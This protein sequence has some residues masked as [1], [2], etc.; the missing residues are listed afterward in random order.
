M[1]F[2]KNNLKGSVCIVLT[3]L[4]L[5]LYSFA[6]ACTD[7]VKISSAE[8]M[9]SKAGELGLAAG[10]SDYNTELKNVYGLYAVSDTNAASED[11]TECFEKSL[12]LKSQTENY[13]NM[14]LFEKEKIS[15]EYPQYAVLA[16]PDILK[17]Q[18]LEYH[19]YEEIS[20]ALRQFISKFDDNKTLNDISS[21]DDVPDD[22]GDSGISGEDALDF[23]QKFTDREGSVSAKNNHSES[24]KSSV[25][26]EQTGLI[27]EMFGKTEKYDLSEVFNND[28]E[29]EYDRKNLY[30]K[31]FYDSF[32]TVKELFS[33]GDIENISDAFITSEYILDYFS[34][35]TDENKKRD[36]E[37][38]N[39]SENNNYLYGRE[40]EYILCGKDDPDRNAESVKTA[41]FS[42]RFVLNSIYVFNDDTIRTAAKAAAAAASVLTHVPEE[43]YEYLFLFSYAAAESKEDTEKLILGEKVPLYK[44]KSALN[45]KP[46]SASYEK[47]DD[48]GLN[49]DLTYRDY[50]ELFL[51]ISLQNETKERDILIR[52]AAIIGTNMKYALSEYKTDTKSDFDIT[53]AYTILEINAEVK[54]DTLILGLFD[55]NTIGKKK[56]LSVKKRKIF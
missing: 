29:N 1:S 17:Y 7:G 37:K 10:M 31:Y 4:M 39:F 48:T 12:P 9:A 25:I 45:I 51:L 27:E 49:V 19:T 32:E 20:G 43:V 34:S 50:M 55:K 15:A 2:F 23:F 14:I 13:N 5:P 46:P 44:S 28:Q 33:V 38:F 36:N 21:S 42:V 40:T 11:L 8:R 26:K 47:E 54:T 6:L 53:R 30:E 41:V 18:I 16:N 22:T 52:T 35:I 24:E 56:I 3:L